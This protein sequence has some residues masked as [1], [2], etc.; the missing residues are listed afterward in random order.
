MLDSHAEHSADIRV[1]D[2]RFAAGDAALAGRLYHPAGPARAAVVL[3]GATGVPQGYY[4]HFARWLA[5]ERQMAC[6]T[7]DYRD[8][9]ASARM[10]PRRSQA[11]MGDWALADQPAARTEMQRHY[12]GVPM[13]VIGHSLGAMLMPL[14]EGLTDV[15]RMIV[16]AGGLVHH[17]D[18]PWPYRAL[19][20]AFWFGHVPALVRALGYLPGRAVGVGAD[21]PAGV[22]WQ[23]RRWCTTPGSYL[24]ETGTTLPQPRWAET[25]IPVDLFAMADDDVV[26]PPAVWRLSDAYGDV[27][28][29]RIVLDPQQAGV[30]KIGHLGAFA[31]ANAALWPRLLPQ[32]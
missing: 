25:G 10:H 13:Y 5:A 11:T 8:F 32:A 14:Q 7:Y 30:Q 2:V 4:R 24:P 26:P 1:E 16:V 12:A 31:R 20:L 22:Y 27:P 3:N 9:G 19:A 23:W 21:L 15:A 28:Q 17:H 18:H 6:L 29:R